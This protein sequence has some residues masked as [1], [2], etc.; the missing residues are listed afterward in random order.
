MLLKCGNGPMFIIKNPMGMEI[1][2][3]IVETSKTMGGR[4]DGNVCCMIVW[5]M[6]LYK[7]D[8]PIRKG[9]HKTDELEFF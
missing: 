1:F 4:R 8:I 3:A 7:K 5:A 6:E 2:G 9:E